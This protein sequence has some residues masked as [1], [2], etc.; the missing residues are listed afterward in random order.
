MAKLKIRAYYQYNGPS[1]KDPLRS[2]LV[3]EDVVRNLELLESDFCHTLGD[4]ATIEITTKKYDQEQVWLSIQ[5][6]CSRE[7][8]LPIIEDVLHKAELLGDII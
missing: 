1:L 8:L 4:N 6:E 5:A 3:H 7:E 2:K